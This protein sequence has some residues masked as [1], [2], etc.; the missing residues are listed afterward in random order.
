MIL[1]TRG[2]LV[3]AIAVA[4][5][6][7]LTG[8]LIGG[9]RSWLRSSLTGDYRLVINMAMAVAVAAALA[10]A[11]RRIRIA[12][13]T[14]F[15]AIAG[16]IS[17]AAV[18]AYLTRSGN[19]D[20]DAVERFHF[21]EYAAV[22]W[23]F[24]RAWIHHRDLSTLALPV[25]MT[26]IAGVADE[27]FQWFV[28]GRVGEWRDLGIN[29]A[30]IASG[31]LFSVAL[32][33]PGALRWRVLP[34]SR[35]ATGIIIAAAALVIAGFLHLVHAGVVVRDVEVGDFT[36]RYSEEAL[37]ALAR[38]R[39]EL[40]RTDPPPMTLQRYS[41]EDQYRSEGVIHIRRRNACWALNGRTA[42][43]E[44]IILEKFYGP[45]L[46]TPGWDTPEA[47]RWPPEQ[48]SDLARRIGSLPLRAPCNPEVPEPWLFL[49]S[50]R[51]L[52]IGA[53]VVAALGLWLARRFPGSSANAS[54]PASV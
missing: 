50:P 19:P 21:V 23:L 17:V 28:P 25:V 5:A 36:S 30:A 6:V 54:W 32:D 24:Y 49:W 12:R 40:W 2:R 53:G 48:R 38:D 52:W 35:R 15:A 46:D 27:A 8:P 47:S 26:F 22:T 14:R 41:R 16:A 44:N 1:S 29:L 45:V 18:F 3:V 51:W 39:H 10:A 42:W 7:V 37:L 9:V 13:V 4:A 11:V 43:R 33:P 34:A 31:L 20:V